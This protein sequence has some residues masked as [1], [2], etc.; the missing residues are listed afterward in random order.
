MVFTTKHLDKVLC[1][2]RGLNQ[3]SMYSHRKNMLAYR[4]SKMSSQ[5]RGSILERMVRDLFISKKK[6]VRYIGGS[7]PFDMMIGRERVEVKSSL[8]TVSVVN[9]KIRYSFKFQ[10]IKTDNFDKLIMIFVSPEGLEIRQMSRAVVR[11]HLSDAAH[12]SNGQTLYVGRT[13]KKLSGKR[14][15]A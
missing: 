4:L 8:A 15:A 6:T 14:I 5:Y 1:E 7:H 3:K 13:V 2:V 12:Y 10:N 9:G 11:K